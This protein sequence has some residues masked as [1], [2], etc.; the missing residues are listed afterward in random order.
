M[1]SQKY[2]KPLL[3]VLA[4]VLGVFV[5]L[6]CELYISSDEEFV[7]NSIRLSL[8]T[9][10]L[11][12]GL[13][14]WLHFFW[15]VL[16]CTLL[17]AGTLATIFAWPFQLFILHFISNDYVPPLSETVVPFIIGLLLIVGALERLEV[18]LEAFVSAE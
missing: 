16:G 13:L 2:L 11:L 9:S 10:I 18:A 6:V 5:W 4:V 17:I 8:Y 7:H 1:T 14:S 12:I 15:P 3:T